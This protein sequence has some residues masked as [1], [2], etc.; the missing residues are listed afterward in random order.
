MIYRSKFKEAR[1]YAEAKRVY[2]SLLHELRLERDRRFKEIEDYRKGKIEE[3][4]FKGNQLTIYDVEVKES[5]SS[6]VGGGVVQRNN[7][8]R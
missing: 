7:R 3:E 6:E 1:S 4:V 8:P 2:S 5:G